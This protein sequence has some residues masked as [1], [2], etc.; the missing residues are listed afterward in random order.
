M[1]IPQF[2]SRTVLTFLVSVL[3]P[4]VMFSW[5]S[6]VTPKFSELFLCK[7]IAP[8]LLNNHCPPFFLFFYFATLILMTFANL[9][10]NDS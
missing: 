8:N 7:Q 6:L 10:S 9:I 4:V 2:Y 1:D 5:L 3:L